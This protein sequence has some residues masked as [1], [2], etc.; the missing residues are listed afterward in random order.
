[1]KVLEKSSNFFLL[2]LCEAGK[3]HLIERCLA[4]GV[5]FDAEQRAGAFHVAEDL[6]QRHVHGR[7]LVM[8]HVLMMLTQLRVTERVGHELLQ[9]KGIR[10]VTAQTHCYCVASTKS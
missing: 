10:P 1:L 7:Q 2:Y 3:Q 5:V 4:D 9:R 8:Q 6:S